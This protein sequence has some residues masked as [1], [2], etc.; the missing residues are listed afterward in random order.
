M[1]IQSFPALGFATIFPHPNQRAQR[2][3]NDANCGLVLATCVVGAVY[4]NMYEPVFF[5]FMLYTSGKLWCVE[6]QSPCLRATLSHKAGLLLVQDICILPQSFIADMK[7]N[8]KGIDWHL[9]KTK[10]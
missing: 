9:P 8:I 2:T 1:D 10:G 3:L 6:F 4:S 5:E 7:R